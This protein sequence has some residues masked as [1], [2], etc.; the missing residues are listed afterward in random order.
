MWTSKRTPPDF[1]SSKNQSAPFGD[2]IHDADYVAGTFGRP[3]EVRTVA[4]RNA[5]GFIEHTTTTYLYKDT[6]VTSDSSFAPAASLVW[7]GSGRV[8]FEKATVYFGP[9]YKS[10][11]TVYPE[12]GKPFSPKLPSRTGYEAEIEY[13]LGLVEG[14]RQKTVLTAKDARDSIELLI[15]ERRSAASGRRIACRPGCMV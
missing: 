2:H 7:E 9:F 4:H 8:F 14:R 11:L 3:K 6:F 15:A 10:P 12:T 5:R 1:F 13:F